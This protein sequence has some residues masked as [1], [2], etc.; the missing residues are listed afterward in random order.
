MCSDVGAPPPWLGVACL[1]SNASVKNRVGSSN[2]GPNGDDEVPHTGCPFVDIQGSCSDLIHGA[3]GGLLSEVSSIVALHTCIPFFL[4]DG[5]QHL[6]TQFW[7]ASD[8]A[9]HQQP[10]S[11]GLARSVASTSEHSR[12]LR[13]YLHVVV[14]CAPPLVVVCLE[15][16]DGSLYILCAQRGDTGGL[17]ISLSIRQ[18]H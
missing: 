16:E 5:R 17:R 6:P 9:D 1:I 14:A 15:S 18:C 10:A 8:L 7:A 3:D 13:R 12:E 11:A 2:Y 4:S